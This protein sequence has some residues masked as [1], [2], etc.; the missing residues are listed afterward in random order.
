MVAATPCMLERQPWLTEGEM[1][2]HED[3]GPENLADVLAK[4]FASRGWARSSERGRLEEAWAESVGAEHQAQTRVLGL[5]RGVLEVEIKNPV[6]M[7]EFAQ[8]RKRSLL[9]SMR[10]RLAGTTISDLKFRA[11]AW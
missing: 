7:Q 9:E 1:A 6:L 10:K 8:F 5:R 4:L 3:R 2:I 11:G